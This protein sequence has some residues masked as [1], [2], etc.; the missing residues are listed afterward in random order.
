MKFLKV[1]SSALILVIALT[2]LVACGAPAPTAAPAAPAPATQAPVATDASKPVAAAPTEAPKAAAASAGGTLVGGFDVGPAGV[3]QV[4]PYNHTGGNTWL[5][6]IWSPLLSY[7]DTL[8]GLEPQLASKWSSNADATKWT[9]TIRPEAKW[10]DGEAVT[11]DDVKF[12]FELI[13]NPAFGW[14]YDLGVA[15]RASRRR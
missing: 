10:N 6:K 15:R 5:M 11:A 12:T 2:M 7:N 13:L 4:R 1:V 8:T 9:F 14:K 3:A